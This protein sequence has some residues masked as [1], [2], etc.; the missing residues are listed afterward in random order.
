MNPTSETRPARRTRHA[1]R[2][3]I[4]AGLLVLAAAGCGAGPSTE[5]A[6]T[7]TNVKGTFQGS[8]FGETPLAGDLKGSVAAYRE[9]I[10]VP[11][12]MAFELQTFHLFSLEDGTFSTEDKGMQAPVDPP[13]YHLSNRYE[14][15][16]GT[17]AYE[18]ASGHIIVHGMLVTDFTG[19]DP[20]NGEIDATY[21][22]TICS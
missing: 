3:S 2:N 6:A 22:G 21:W 4:L 10:V 1:P 20:R 17:G 14:I 18:K 15:V 9:P 16:S 12:G 11:K 5:L 19:E 7:C 8:I 13:V